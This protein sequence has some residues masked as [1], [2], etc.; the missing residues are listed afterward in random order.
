MFMID[1]LLGVFLIEVSVI[2]C[3]YRSFCLVALVF[4]ACSF[5]FV[6]RALLFLFFLLSLLSLLS[7][8]LSMQQVNQ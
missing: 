7:L 5:P 4:V 1:H 8:C 6:F 2:G 3:A